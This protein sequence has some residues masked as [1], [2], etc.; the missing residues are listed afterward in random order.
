MDIKGYVLLKSNAVTIQGVQ[1]APLEN[2]R[3]KICN[4]FDIAVDEKSLMVLSS[5]GTGLGDF[6][7]EQVQSWFK[8]GSYGDV[9]LPPNLK[10][11]EKFLYYSK[12]LSRKG[13]YGPLI[14]RMVIAA[15]LH[16]GEFHDSLLWR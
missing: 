4:I 15:S 1:T 14:K 13:G 2:F 10:E 5:C 6:S 12:A 3:N 16:K 8:C 11:H 9:L 7:I